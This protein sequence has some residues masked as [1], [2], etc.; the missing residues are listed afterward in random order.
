METEVRSPRDGRVVS[1]AVKP[2]DTVVVGDALIM[3]D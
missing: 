2:G 3:L 1:V